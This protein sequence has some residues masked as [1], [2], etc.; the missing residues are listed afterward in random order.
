MNFSSKWNLR[1]LE[2]AKHVSHWSKDPSTK[3]GAV[4]V[5]PDKKIVSLGYNGLPI[6]IE[7]SEEI[8]NNRELKYLTIIHAEENAII[9]AQ[10]PLKGCTIF[11]FPMISCPNC[12][13]KVINSGISEIVCPEEFPDRED[14]E[15]R[16]KLSKKLYKEA[17]INVTLINNSAIS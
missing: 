14:W 16:M 3:C 4:I 12:T 10:R 13:T 6:G 5:N 17:N 11:T 9:S 8:L 15:E 2:L 1:F 7:D